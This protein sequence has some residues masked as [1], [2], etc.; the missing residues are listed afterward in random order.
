[1]VAGR[2]RASE[3]LDE[4]KRPRSRRPLEE[5]SPLKKT[6][7]VTKVLEKASPVLAKSLGP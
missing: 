7:A 3:R 4:L 1:M 2:S 6:D 5:T